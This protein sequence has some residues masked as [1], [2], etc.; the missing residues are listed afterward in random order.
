M[1][2]THVYLCPRSARIVDVVPSHGEVYFSTRD[3]TATTLWRAPFGFPPHAIAKLGGTRLI[4]VEED[5][6]ICLDADGTLAVRDRNG[7]HLHVLRVL[8]PLPI[9]T[10]VT[11][12]HVVWCSAREVWRWWRHGEV[13]E[14]LGEHG[15]AAPRLVLRP[16]P[17]PYPSHRFAPDVAIWAG[18][19]VG[20][21]DTEGLEVLAEAALD[22]EH[23]ACTTSAMFWL[24]GVHLTRYD[25]DTDTAGVAAEI[26]GLAMSLAARDDALYLATNCVQ[27]PVPD[28]PAECDPPARVGVLEGDRFVTSTHLAD[29]RWIRNAMRLVPAAG[30]SYLV[31]RGSGIDRL[32]F[33]PDDR[34]PTKR[35]AWLALERWLADGRGGQIMIAHGAWWSH[36]VRGDIP[37]AI[38]ERVNEWLQDNFDNA[39]RVN[40]LPGASGWQASAASS[41]W[42]AV[43]HD[44][45]SVHALAI[46]ELVT[47]LAPHIAPL[48]LL[49]KLA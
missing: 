2:S 26:E 13:V 27:I 36:G 4:A 46:A 19:R 25:L 12:E 22:I 10:V 11:P 45:V 40:Q 16:V 28:A 7:G 47:M 30:G 14:R 23:F 44:R 3:A 15:V 48:R 31:E 33:L 6:L 8:Q 41:V 49:V 35:D 32:A 38:T 18:K 34:E 21:V 43:E 1:L 17:R 20:L 24:V 42:F 37:P 29:P 9:E 5:G 39:E